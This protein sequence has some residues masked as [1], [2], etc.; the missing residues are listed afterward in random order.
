[1][2]SLKPLRNGV[3]ARKF[4][5]REMRRTITE[6]VENFVA[7]EMLKRD[8]KRGDEIVIRMENLRS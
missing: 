5:A 6:L 3:T 8:V 1:M 2:K 7:D 4:G